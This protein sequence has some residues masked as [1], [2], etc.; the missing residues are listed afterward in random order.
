MENKSQADL[1]IY[2]ISV[3]YCQDSWP[4]WYV[5][6][7]EGP[8]L[9]WHLTN[10]HY[11]NIITFILPELGLAVS[12][13]GPFVTC[14]EHMRRPS[15]NTTRFWRSI[16]TTVT[17]HQMN[18]CKTRKRTEWEIIVTSLLSLFSPTVLNADFLCLYY[19]HYDFSVLNM[20]ITNH[21]LT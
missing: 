1:S 18:T 8:I 20:K 9:T 17:L 19:M 4:D 2:D 10:Q 7:N 12:I 21:P 15:A 14:V 6:F 3:P 5:M 13:K 16:V 11:I